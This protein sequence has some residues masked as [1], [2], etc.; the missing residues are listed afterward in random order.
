LRILWEDFGGGGEVISREL[1]GDWPVNEVQVEIVYPEVLQGLLQPTTNVLSLVVSVPQ[2]RSDE[3]IL[4]FDFARRDNLVQ[5]LANL[6]LVLIH[7]T[8]VEQAVAQVDGGLDC[9]LPITQL[10]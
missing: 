8:A 5:G 1:E 7:G 3:D 10:L 4:A 2:L 9:L 6:L